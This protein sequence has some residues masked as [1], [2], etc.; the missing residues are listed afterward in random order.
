MRCLNSHLHVKCCCD[1]K[2]ILDQWNCSTDQRSIWKFQH[3]QFWYNWC[4]HFLEFSQYILIKAGYI[5]L[6]RYQLGGDFLSA[7]AAAAPLTGQVNR[8]ENT[9]RSQQAVLRVCMHVLGASEDSG[10]GQGFLFYSRPQWIHL[11]ERYLAKPSH[12]RTGPSLVSTCPQTHWNTNKLA[13]KVPLRAS[14]PV[15]VE[16]GRK[17]PSVSLLH[18]MSTDWL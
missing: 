15:W 3:Q 5:Y 1:L 13:H 10:W 7:A 14:R 2:H 11:L 12:W 16:G 9:V 6:A 17:Q 8:K 18:L 4:A